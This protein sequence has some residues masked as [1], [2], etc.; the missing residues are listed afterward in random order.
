MPHDHGHGGL[1]TLAQDQHPGTTADTVLDFPDLHSLCFALGKV[2]QHLH[3]WGHGDLGA[4]LALA[5]RT[6]SRLREQ[7]LEVE[8]SLIAGE[9]VGIL[10]HRRAGGCYATGVHEV[11]MPQGAPEEA[12]DGDDPVGQPRP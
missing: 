10:L 5:A 3:R 9:R 7:L 12:K 2:S 8:R 1:P 11:W 4:P 6:A